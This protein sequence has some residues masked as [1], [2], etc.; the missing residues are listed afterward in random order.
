MSELFAGAIGNK[1]PAETICARD[2]FQAK[3]HSDQSSGGSI[4]SCQ[5]TLGLPQSAAPP[6]G[7][8]SCVPIGK[9]YL[10]CMSSICVTFNT[11]Y[12]QSACWNTSEQYCCLYRTCTC[13]FSI[14]RSVSRGKCSSN[15]CLHKNI[16]IASVIIA[17]I[18]NAGHVPTRSHI[19]GLISHLTPQEPWIQVW[20]HRESIRWLHQ[21]YYFA[22][23]EA[24]SIELLARWFYNACSDMVRFCRAPHV[25]VTD[26]ADRLLIDHCGKHDRAGKAHFQ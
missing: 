18:S 10:E 21:A 9:T 6:A 3:H 8:C 25:G 2:L 13:R 12:V 1:D 11:V 16:V 19:I 20:Q 24:L 5:C 23:L 17:S 14:M 26:I 4:W 22:T 7:G 15:P